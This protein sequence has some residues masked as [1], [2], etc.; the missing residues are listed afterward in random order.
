MKKCSLIVILVLTL[1]F[2]NVSFADT[3]YSYQQTQAT[4]TYNS[5]Y[6][7]QPLQY[8][9]NNPLQ[10]NVTM[11]PAGETT[12]AVLTTPLSSET[13]VQGQ[14]VSLVLEDDFYYGNSL[15]APAGSSVYGNVIEVSKAKRGGI[16]GKLCVRFNQIY[17]PYGT[18]IPISAVIKTNDSSGVLQGG[19]KFDVTKEYTKDLA[20]GSA[21]G[22]L[23]G[24]VFGALAGGEVGK[25]AALG[26]A[27]GAGGGLV[28]S[29]WDK[30]NDVEIPM[31]ATIDIMF[32]QPITVNSYA[33]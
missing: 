21:T 2:I 15:I 24:L 25:G 3:N 14:T 13:C 11:V 7:Q 30:G 12:N 31:N 1:S 9:Q 18:Q 29:L 17:T 16:N 6:V 10:G 32:L 19:T 27:V 4:S 5:Q 23:S 8:A 26:T 22:A 33:Y 28:K 20:V